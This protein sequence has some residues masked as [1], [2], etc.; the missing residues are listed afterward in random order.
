MLVLGVLFAVYLGHVYWVVRDAPEE[1]LLVVSLGN[2]PMQRFI[3]RQELFS[4]IRTAETN[5]V[6]AL[7]MSLSLTSENHIDAAS[8]TRLAKDLLEAGVDI[9]GRTATGFPPLHRAINMVEPD[10]VA[11]LLENCADPGV[12]MPLGPSDDAIQMNAIEMAYFM[13]REFPHMDYSRVVAVL[14]RSDVG[15]QCENRK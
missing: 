7:S 9:N 1:L 4:R 10:A 15:L 13:E 12:A 3:A 6:D 5:G 2:E 11:F 14:E 8:A